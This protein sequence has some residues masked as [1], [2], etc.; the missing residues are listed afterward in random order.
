MKLKTLLTLELA[1]KITAEVFALADKHKLHPLA[2][3]VLDIGG[4][5]IVIRRQ[6]G[7]GILRTDIA[8]GKAWGSLG[9]GMASRTIRDRLADRPNFQS[10]LAAASQGRFIP[11]P[12]GV[13]IYNETGH[14]IGAVGISGDASEKDEFCAIE[15]VKSAGLTP[16][17][18]QPHPDWKKAEL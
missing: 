12:G 13:L 17:P 11:V 2:V 4:N 14:A 10:G 8:I 6:D 16:D 9:M 7:T 1:D 15:A 3:A 18:D 5:P